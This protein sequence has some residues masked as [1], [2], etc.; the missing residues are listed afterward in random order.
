MDI[1]CLGMRQHLGEE[2]SLSKLARRLR[3]Q[4]VLMGDMFG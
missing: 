1:A 2:V 4:R 3:Y